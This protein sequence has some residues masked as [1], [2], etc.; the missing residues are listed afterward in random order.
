VTHFSGVPSRSLALGKP[1]EVFL[2]EEKARLDQQNLAALHI[3]HHDKWYATKNIVEGKEGM[4]VAKV[5]IRS[6]LIG[7]IGG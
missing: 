4:S 7:W 2:K 1:K 3:L 5:R 6:Y